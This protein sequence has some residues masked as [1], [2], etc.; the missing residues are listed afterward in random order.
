MEIIL[1]AKKIIILDD[2][3]KTTEPS[4][5]KSLTHLA[6]CLLVRVRDFSKLS[7]Y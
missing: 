1:V 6:V 4:V 5:C 3:W 7:I 2:K